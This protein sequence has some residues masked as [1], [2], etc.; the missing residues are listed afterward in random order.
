M[1]NSADFNLATE[2][3][4]QNVPPSIYKTVD[5]DRRF[6]YLA[7]VYSKHEGGLEQGYMDAC[8]MMAFMMNAG[9]H[10]YTPIAHNH[11]A[12]RWINRLDHDYWLPIDF[13]FLELSKGLIV[14]KMTNWEKS[15][16]IAEEIKYATELGLPIHYTNFLEMP[17]DL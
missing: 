15:F 3:K 5:K 7:T 9:I 13:K 14:C 12:A 17:K 11:V 2:M 6:W 1:V 4:L 10:V 16:G 8:E